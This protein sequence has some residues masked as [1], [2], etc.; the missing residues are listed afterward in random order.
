[1]AALPVENKIFHKRDGFIFTIVKFLFICR[2]IP[3]TH[4]HRVYISFDTIFQIS[5]WQFMIATI[6]IWLMDTECMSHNDQQDVTFAVRPSSSCLT[7]AFIFD[8]RN[9][10]DVISAK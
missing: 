10:T 3:A 6:I 2:N 9:R 5:L 4:R 1:M 8:T 7:T